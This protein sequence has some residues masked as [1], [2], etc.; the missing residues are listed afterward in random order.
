[1]GFLPRCLRAP[2]PLLAAL[3]ALAQPAMSAAQP[4]DAPVSSQRVVHAF[5]FEEQAYNAEEVP[6][7]WVRAQHYLPDRDRPG[8]PEWNKAGFDDSRA[9]SGIYS[10]KAPSASR[11]A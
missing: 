1:M 6:Q 4:M 10:V 8:Y 9:V 5:D 3:L 7:Y 2:R 11:Q